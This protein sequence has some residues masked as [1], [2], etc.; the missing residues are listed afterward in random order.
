METAPKCSHRIGA[1]ATAQAAES[2]TIPASPPRHGI[3]LEATLEARDEDED[4]RH[5]GEGELEARVEQR[6]R[7]PREQ[8]RR[9]DE[10]EVPAIARSRR[11]PRKRR[12][13]ARD[14]RPHDGRL[15]ADGGDVPEHRG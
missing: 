10:R 7:I 6:V 3:P 13:P 15:P 8:D 12:E 14:S 2:A 5:C 9:A 11:E 1:V 4:G